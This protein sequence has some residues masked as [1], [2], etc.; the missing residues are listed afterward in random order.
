MNLRRLSLRLISGKPA[1]AVGGAKFRSSA[2]RGLWLELEDREGN[3]GFGEAS[4]LP[5]YS[6]DTL[7]A[8]QRALEALAIEHVDQRASDRATAFLARLAA[9]RDLLP[10]AL[11]AA[12]FAL[13]TAVLDL[14]CKLQGCSP[15]E[16]L[17]RP[18][19]QSVPVSALIDD[20]GPSAVAEAHAQLARGFGT[21]KLKLG[22]DV[23]RELETLRLVA[24][25]VRARLRVDANQS[26]SQRECSRILPAL[27]QLNLEFIEEPCPPSVWSSLPLQRPRLALD[28]SLQGMAPVD[29][30]ALVERSGASVLV[31]KPMALGG[32]LEC[33]ALADCAE[34]LGLRVV[35]TH[36]F[37]GPIAHRAASL[38][39]LLVQGGG[40]AAG[41]APH[42]GLDI[43][44]RM[45]LALS[46]A[47]LV[48]SAFRAGVCPR[49][50]TE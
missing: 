40:L 2:R 43:H 9:A 38:L 4:P 11:P 17:G 30:P 31:L 13:E 47:E 8:C 49:P 39:A 48:A 26:L 36:L 45:E 3:I 24:D 23:E 22:R 16:L 42:A 37:D 44:P 5:G 46:G 33:L 27:S 41:L 12:R 21:L 18:L 19:S 28:E 25:S 34:G 1:R 15:S 32:L 10:R 14:E 50:I 7:E 29:L 6:P 35:V 20:L